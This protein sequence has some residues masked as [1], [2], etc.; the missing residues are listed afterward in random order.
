MN[1]GSASD[2]SI[3]RNAFRVLATASVVPVDPRALARAG[4]DALEREGVHAGSTFVGSDV[5]ATGGVL[6]QAVARALSEQPRS[7]AESPIWTAIAA[8]AESVGDPHTM[9]WPSHA[10]E[11]MGHMVVGGGSV[12]AP[13]FSLHRS[14]EQFVVSDIYEGGP[15]Q[16]ADLRVGDVVL[17]VGGQ[18]L[19]RGQFEL[20]RWFGVPEHTRLVVRVERRGH[21]TPFDVTL[22]LVS[23][24]LVNSVCKVLE[25]GVGYVRLRQMTM[26]EDPTID[27]RDLVV[28]AQQRFEAQGVR[29]LILDLRSNTGGLGVS[30]LASLFTDEDPILVYRFVD[31]HEEPAVRK[32][33]AWPRR[34]PL[35]VLVNEQTHSA[36]EMV[37]LALDDR[38]IAPIVGQPS[39]GALTLPHYLPMRDGHALSYS[40]AHALGPL[41]RRVLEGR[42]IQ[43]LR[44]IANP[45]ADDLLAGR[46]AQLQAA[47]EHLTRA[48]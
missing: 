37:A 21:D 30:K 45:T 41:S 25:P 10:F 31:G 8:M 6:E 24:R 35:A 44:I 27:A 11:A 13:G 46:D 17:A 36:A 38:R 28:E 14:G 9:L 23:H 40:E 12:V 3:F 39:A 19:R 5:E 18:P 48:P 2:A 1:D 47:L 16:R 22:D 29:A 33:A 43:P 15:A 32:G 7:G 42:R 4:L 20:L 26:C 34:P